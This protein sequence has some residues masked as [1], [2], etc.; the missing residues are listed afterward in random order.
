MSLTSIGMQRSICC[1]SA[2]AALLTTCAPPALAATRYVSSAS[3]QCSN[4]GPGTATAPYCTI[5]AA[6]SIAVPGDT[7]VVASG[8][9]HERV[10]VR[11]SGTPEAPIA[12]AADGA[13]VIVTGA[14]HG[15]Y[16]SGRRWI[17]LRGFTVD[18]TLAAGILVTGSS[19]ITISNN[20]VTRAG[21]P[22]PGYVRAGISLNDTSDSLV[23]GNIAEHNT[24]AGIK[25]DYG[26]TRNRI[27]G[28]ITA[29]NA[30]RYAR[31]SPGIDV[32]S[33]GNTVE[34]N[35]SHDNED[36][37]IQIYAGATNN[38]IR[39][40]LCYNNGDHGID[41]LRSGGQRII[42][43]SV[44]RN[45][46]AGINVEGGSRGTTLANNISVDNAMGG[47]RTRGNIRVDA[48]SIPG[49]R[50]D[51][52][53]IYLTRPDVTIT[54][55]STRY[56]SLAAFVAAT[57]ME[58]HGIQ[59]DPLWVSP[60]TGDFHLTAG[61]PGIDSAD[62]GASGAHDADLEFRPRVDDPGAAAT[63]AGPRGYDD[64]GAFEYQP[65]PEPGSGAATAEDQGF[66]ISALRRKRMP[67]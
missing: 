37:G 54:W 53:L 57:G 41:V 22:T 51:Y 46:A 33:G 25:L 9:Y 35:I 3:A 11:N 63:G 29:H 55:G 16:I 49:T 26:A 4:S 17:A 40:N 30:R 56:T 14:R 58:S 60:A 7:V 24:D 59:A 5:S 42:G 50:I 31:A 47:P 52:D 48:D 27:V 6:A 43:N 38:L 8:V 12:F 1:A 36:S 45:E 44:Y 23:S 62:S 18:D 67:A 61:S 13:D 10:T 28:N 21:K 34:A 65:R 15:F 20:H 2:L 32:R 39:N 64:R 66:H 19:H